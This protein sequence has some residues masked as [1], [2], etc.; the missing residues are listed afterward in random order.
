ML[1]TFVEGGCGNWSCDS[2]LDCLKA[3]GVEREREHEQCKRD[4]RS[5]RETVES[6]ASPLLKVAE[7]MAPSLHSS[8]TIYNC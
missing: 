7:T 2:G 6:R 8:D 5:A 4:S 1:S 3:E